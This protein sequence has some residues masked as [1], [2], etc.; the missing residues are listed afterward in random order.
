ML[1]AIR[2]VP[3]N[4]LED[5]IGPAAATIPGLLNLVAWGDSATAESALEDLRD[6]V[7]Q[8]GSF[9]HQATA[10]VVPFLF[11]LARGPQ[12]TCRPK[13]LGL[14]KDIGQAR[15][16]ETAAS[17]LVRSRGCAEHARWEREARTAVRAGLS[18][19][20]HLENE[21]DAAVSEAASELTRALTA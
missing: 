7:C 19:A 18:I 10:P 15:Q 17:T 16:W 13:V 12:V 3:W 2:R 21:P 20:R 11:E 1:K 8:Y 6:R 5:S 14:L 9:V 4:E